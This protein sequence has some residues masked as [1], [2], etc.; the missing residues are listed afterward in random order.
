M[1]NKNEALQA[2]GFFLQLVFYCRK[3]FAKYESKEYTIMIS[4]VCVPYLVEK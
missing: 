1:I 4:W 2:A 3:I